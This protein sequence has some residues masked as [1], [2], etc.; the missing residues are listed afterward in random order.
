V[1][2][3]IKQDSMS[4]PFPSHPDNPTPINIGEPFVN[5]E[6][7]PILV[8]VEQ[9]IRQA[10]EQNAR[11]GYELLF[12]RFYRPLCSHAVRYVYGREVAE[13]IVSDV[14]LNFWHTQAYQI[15]LRPPTRPIS[16]VRCVIGCLITFGTRRCTILWMRDWWH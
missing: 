14:F 7:P 4:Q 15:E 12:R 13:D 6:R 2:I 3:R 5:S 8:D 1:S 10:F 9:L 11:Q 16:S